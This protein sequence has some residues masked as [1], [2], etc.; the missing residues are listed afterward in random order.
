ML[1]SGEGVKNDIGVEVVKERKIRVWV[2]R[3]WKNIIGV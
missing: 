2:V 1:V 3:R